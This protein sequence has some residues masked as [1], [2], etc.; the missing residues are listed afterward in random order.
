[1]KQVIDGFAKR[2]KENLAEESEGYR[3]TFYESQDKFYGILS[4]T[5]RWDSIL[6]WAHYANYHQGFCVGFDKDKLDNSKLFGKGGPVDY[7]DEFP[8][9]DPFDEDLVKLGFTETHTK[10]K[11]WDYE[12]EYRLFQRDKNGFTPEKRKI[13]I[14]DDYFK[15]IIIGLRFPQADI[16]KIKRIADSKQIKAY[17]VVKIDSRFE[18]DRIEI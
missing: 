12:K 9:I 3:Q 18:L 11:N 5:Y 10:A 13:S 2:L 14:P 17:R 16:S 7:K 8:R 15:E 4:L 1:M 6:M